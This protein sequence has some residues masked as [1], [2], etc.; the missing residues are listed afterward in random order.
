MPGSSFSSS[1]TTTTSD[2]VSESS[3]SMRDTLVAE[4]A[5]AE[6]SFILPP[7]SRREPGNPE[8]PA[9]GIFRFNTHHSIYFPNIP[10]QPVNGMI[11]SF[12]GPNPRTF[13]RPYSAKTVFFYKDG[14]EY[15]TGV[16]VPISKA[17]YRTMNSLMDSL[18][19][20][21]S[22]PFGVR[23]LHTPYGRTSIHSIEQ[24][25]HLGRYVASS[26]KPLRRINIDGFEKKRLRRWKPVL[27]NG[28]SLQEPQ[29]SS[30]NNSQKVSID[31]K[32]PTLYKARMA[33]DTGRTG[34][35]FLPITAKQM[36]F[37]LNGHPTR[38]YRTLI[39]PL[40]PRDFDSLLEEISQGLQTAIFKLYSYDG[41]R[42][43][44]VDQ[45]VTIKEARALA[46]PR[47][48]RPILT[49]EQA[50]ILPPI[51]KSIGSKSSRGSTSSQDEAR[52]AGRFTA[53]VVHL[54]S[55]S[56]GANGRPMP[57][58]PPHRGSF[59]ADDIRMSR[60]AMAGALAVNPAVPR[61][62]ANSMFRSKRAT[63][64]L[65][66]PEAANQ[67]NLETAIIVSKESDILS[68][69]SKKVSTDDSGTAISPNFGGSGSQNGVGRSLPSTSNTLD[70]D[71][72]RPRSAS[73][74]LL[75][76]DLERKTS[77]EYQL[78][79][80][81]SAH[82]RHSAQNVN[83][84]TFSAKRRDSSRSDREW[85]DRE[86]QDPPSDD[87]YPEQPEALRG[88]LEETDGQWN[89]EGETSEHAVLDSLAEEDESEEI[90]GNSKL[91]E[92][93]E[94]PTTSARARIKRLK[95]IEEMPESSRLSSSRV[96]DTEQPADDQINDYDEIQNTSPDLPVVS[97][98]EELDET[99]D[100]TPYP[101]VPSSRGMNNDEDGLPD[102][103]P[104]QAATVIQA[105]WRGYRVRKVLK[106]TQFNDVL[107]II[108]P[109]EE[110][111]SA[112]LDQLPIDLATP[113]Q[114]G[115]DNNA[116][117]AED[118]NNLL[119]AELLEMSY[120]EK[121]MDSSSDR[122]GDEVHGTNY[123]VA[124]MGGLLE[125]SLSSEGLDKK[126][127]KDPDGQFW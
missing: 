104:N 54:K 68:K 17:R 25:E 49:G 8:R 126:P 76:A 55:K 85:V 67:T 27:N 21:I 84:D 37:V 100:F 78:P 56:T 24:L 122:E 113:E 115:R 26:S 39:N 61:Q 121:T 38:I 35:N 1:T 82:R 109:E 3:E 72:G 7:S 44:S 30:V 12:P 41:E 90:Q 103:D 98:R 50:F 96:E 127:A 14:D 62:D 110:D 105:N 116:G 93:I 59:T 108:H 22:L 16:R 80:E 73:D 63:S 29:T 79:S 97:P 36:F 9:V 20:N 42:I 33:V 53:P 86:G 75:L 114:D 99:R 15:F 118:L 34:N 89:E 58:I 92:E 43:W 87:D 101:R 10:A 112:D 81:G 11:K 18:N 95:T 77:S 28:Q 5:A 94:S 71:S 2:T 120:V 57:H 23:R 91:A 32:R 125:P 74:D 6:E 13:S 45:L 60:R 83:L 48:E 111:N 46:V 47:H 117:E 119:G 124:E 66:K 102:L 123:L 65:V 52:A 106:K 4:S 88:I 69:V 51:G 31:H 64:K 19:D 107:E 70:S 40:K